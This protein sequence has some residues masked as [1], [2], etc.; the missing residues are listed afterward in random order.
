[1]KTA[2]VDCDGA[3]GN[4]PALLTPVITG[5]GAPAGM[6]RSC[7]D[8]LAQS[9][10]CSAVRLSCNVFLFLRERLPR[11]SVGAVLHHLYVRLTR[12]RQ[13]S[14]LPIV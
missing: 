10:E 2:S 12:S 1:M 7:S 3:G 13:N 14:Q 9:G 11:H 4:N 8:Q 5:A 6:P